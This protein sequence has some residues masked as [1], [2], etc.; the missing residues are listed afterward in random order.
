MADYLDVKSKPRF[1]VFGTSNFTIACTDSIREAGADVVAMITLPPEDLP[2]NAADIA[3]Y[4]QENNLRCKFIRD[5]NGQE[6]IEYLNHI[7]P[8]YILSS[9]PNLMSQR[10]IDLPN[11]FIIGSHPTTLPYNR[12][13]HPLHWMIVLG[14]KSTALSF[15]IVNAGVDAGPILHQEPF[16]L[17][18]D[19]T[20]ESA[21]T[22]MEQAGA[23]GIK[24]VYEAILSN[25]AFSG[26]SQDQSL[27]NTWRKRTPSD[28]TIDPRLTVETIIQMVRSFAPPYPCAN[29]LFEHY[30]LKIE[31]ARKALVN[32]SADESKRTE[33]GKILTISK[34]KL[35]FKVAD[36]WIELN[37]TENVPKS[38]LNK[39]YIHPPTYYL[40]KY[41]SEFGMIFDV[42]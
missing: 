35:T 14:I 42:D 34:N 16:E 11:N 41:P 28:V 15:F 37:C 4:A 32:M 30:L 38:L 27:A 10:V 13:R 19:E 23:R 12:G 31:V 7:N 29:L 18:L 1:V 9:W 6:S 22:K 33:Y 36:G 20:V 3:S 25:P 24:R 17:D 39:R 40:A 26:T 21:N 2:D 8:D 5:I